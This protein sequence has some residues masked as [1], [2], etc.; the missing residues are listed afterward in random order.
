MQT[1][2]PYAAQAGHS[3]GGSIPPSYYPTQSQYNPNGYAPQNMGPQANY[4]PNY[5]AYHNEWNNAPNVPY[6]SYPQGGP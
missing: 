6:H 3:M 2:P 1:I 5:Q 4:N